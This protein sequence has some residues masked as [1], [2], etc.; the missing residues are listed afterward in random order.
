MRTGGICWFWCGI[1]EGQGRNAPLSLAIAG[2][3]NEKQLEFNVGAAAA[4]HRPKIY[5]R[6]DLT[7]LIP[8][9]LTRPWTYRCNP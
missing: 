2:L 7:H 5:A 8:E 6:R 9:R 4:I 3:Q 1:S